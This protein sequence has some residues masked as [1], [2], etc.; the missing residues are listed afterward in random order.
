MT[1]PVPV[2]PTSLQHLI[3]LVI[4]NAPGELVRLDG[5]YRRDEHAV[6]VWGR[7]PNLNCSWNPDFG[8]KSDGLPLDWQR[9]SKAPAWV[10]VDRAV[11]AYKV[12][13]DETK[14]TLAVS[15]TLVNGQKLVLPNFGGEVVVVCDPPSG[16]SIHKWVVA[17]NAV[18]G[19][20]YL[21]APSAEELTRVWNEFVETPPAKKQFTGKI[22]I[23]REVWNLLTPE[24]QCILLPHVLPAAP[25]TCSNCK[26]WC[27]P[28]H[29]PI[30]R[31]VDTIG[32]CALAATD[33][34]GAPDH[35]EALAYVA[36][37][38]AYEGSLKTRRDFSCNQWTPV[39]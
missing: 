13:C 33:S 37:Q 16:L 29:G 5:Y 22:T 1:A 9:S 26:H 23:D 21:A 20:V 19:R 14:S 11:T 24:V 35:P 4:A 32:D 17:D 27:K 6:H 38:S 7:V 2:R 18:Y 36:G 25:P 39:E 34:S 3:E 10:N 31:E 30:N 15:S 28:W 12:T 8:N